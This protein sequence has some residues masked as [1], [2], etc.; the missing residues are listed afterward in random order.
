MWPFQGKLS[1]EKAACSTSD[2]TASDL[3]LRVAMMFPSV[4]GR[5]RGWSP[6]PVAA[7]EREEVEERFDCSTSITISVAARSL[8]LHEGSGESDYLAEFI[9]SSGFCSIL[10]N[11]PSIIKFVSAI[12]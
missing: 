4:T 11:Y 8:D 9:A 1:G 6:V 12:N 2:F 7:Q 10:A 3:C 5:D